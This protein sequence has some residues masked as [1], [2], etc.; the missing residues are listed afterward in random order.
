MN[1]P[2]PKVPEE[3]APKV[4]ALASRLYTAE[5]QGYSLTELIE[6]GGEAQIPPQFVQQALEQIQAEQIKLSHR[7]NKLKVAL[8]GGGIAIVIWGVWT[9]NS[10]SG[11]AQR[12]DS[13]WAQVENQ[14]QRRSDLIPNTSSL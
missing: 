10:L 14:F 2:D 7:Q 11:A 6:A 3:L 12:V 8:I 1:N 9:Y 5:N 4:F 13:A